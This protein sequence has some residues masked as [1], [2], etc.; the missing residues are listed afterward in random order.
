[1][2]AMPWE[3]STLTP[4]FISGGSEWFRGGGDG[5]GEGRERAGLDDVAVGRPVLMF[6]SPRILSV[7]ELDRSC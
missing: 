1:M 2:V 3:I 7:E 6:L 5:G 4:G